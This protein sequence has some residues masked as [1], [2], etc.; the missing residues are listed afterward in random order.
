MLTICMCKT[1]RVSLWT[2]TAP[3]PNPN[4]TLI[5]CCITQIAQTFNIILGGIPVIY[6]PGTRLYLTSRSEE[7]GP[8]LL[9]MSVVKGR[10]WVL[11]SHFAGLPRREDFEIVEEELPSIKNGGQCLHTWSLEYQLLLQFFART[12]FSKAIKAQQRIAS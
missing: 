3:K 5:P 11:R 2:L 9:R 4:H 1:V 6:F 7:L 10:K 12:L 8:R